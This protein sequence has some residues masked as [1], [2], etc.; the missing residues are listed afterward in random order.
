M[1][2]GRRRAQSTAIAIGIDEEWAA[3]DD[4]SG[5]L[6]ELLTA[7]LIPCTPQSAVET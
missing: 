6:C 1:H 7:P 2:A 5:P 3:G 4:I